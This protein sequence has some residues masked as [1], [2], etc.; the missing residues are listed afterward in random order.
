MQNVMRL[1]A[2]YCE[3]RITDKYLIDTSSCAFLNPTDKAPYLEQ[4]M[5]M[6]DRNLAME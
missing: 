4:G 5:L 3:H 1:T 6:E 2:R